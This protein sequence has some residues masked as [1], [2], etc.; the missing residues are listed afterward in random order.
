MAAE[1]MR[2]VPRSKLAGLE[3]GNEPDTYQLFDLYPGH[4]IRPKDFGPKAYLRQALAHERA[5]ARAA[6]GAPIAGPA[7]IGGYPAWLRA[8]PHLLAAQRRY[9]KLVTIHSYPLLACGHRKISP[10]A[11]LSRSALEARAG[12]IAGLI[13]V[14]G[15]IHRRLRISETNSIAC[16]GSHGA[17]DAFASALWGADWAF[18]VA[19]LHGDGVNFHFA[20]PAY[21]P[22]TAGATPTGP[23]ARVNPLYYGMLLFAAATPH[24]ARI[25]P[26]SFKRL[27]PR[28]RA[29]VHAWATFDRVDRVV[30]V[31]VIDKDRRASGSVVVHVPGARGAGTLQRLLAPSVTSTTGVTWAG[32]S[33][34]N[35][36]FDGRLQ[37]RRVVHR[38]SRLRGDRFVVSMPAHSAALLTVP[39]RGG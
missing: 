19:A 16:G 29:N 15:R 9:L 36:T 31:A 4:P 1:V 2:S 8:F 10:W 39:A 18:L 5:I 25:L 38:V 13:T 24:G 32:Q 27:R 35:P 23:A 21:A 30:R 12:L 26:G 20:A 11:L 6:P 33:F 22:F 17:S 37:G 34:A 7:T 14:A 3:L 28:G